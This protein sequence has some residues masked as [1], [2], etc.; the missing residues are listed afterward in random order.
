MG[1][2]LTKEELI[3]LIHIISSRAK[4][5]TRDI[6]NV[7]TPTGKVM[8]YEGLMQFFDYIDDYPEIIRSQITEY[9]L[10]RMENDSITP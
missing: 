7:H 6:N 3:K 1:E 4:A 2:P 8:Y 10:F 9:E 5:L